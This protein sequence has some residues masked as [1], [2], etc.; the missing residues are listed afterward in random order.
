MLRHTTIVNKT[1]IITCKQIIVFTKEM[2]NEICSVQNL[3][4]SNRNNAFPS[5]KCCTLRTLQ[6]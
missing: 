3:N 1:C 2:G 5:S 6:C 4:N